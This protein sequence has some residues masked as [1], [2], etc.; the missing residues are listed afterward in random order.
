MLLTSDAVEEAPTDIRAF[1]FISYAHLD[2]DAFLSKLDN[3]LQGVFGN[4]FAALYPDA[5]V[6]FQ[7]F[8]EAKGRVLVPAGQDEFEASMT[9]V[10]GSGQRLPREAHRRAEFLVRRLLGAEIEI[11]IDLKDWLDSV[12]P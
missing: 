4:P 10:H 5:V 2:P 6:L 9:A 12:S 11:L 8:C 3:A 7:Q 1:E